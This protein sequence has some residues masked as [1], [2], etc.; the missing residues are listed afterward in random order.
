MSNV[1]GVLQ[2]YTTATQF[3]AAMQ[4]KLEQQEA[5]YGLMLGIALRLQAHPERIEQPPYLATVT[6]DQGTTAALMT[7]PHGLLLYSEQAEHTTALQLIADD[8]HANAWPLPT[9]NG[10]TPLSTTFAQIWSQLCKGGYE[11]A[12]RTRIFELR[13]VQSPPACPGTMRLATGA[14]LELVTSWVIAFE[15][16]ALSEEEADIA[17]PSTAS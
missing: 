7:P 3:L 2:T 16:E 13:Q 12:V 1:N 10:L 8:L 14:D 5:L 4:G 11:V 6:D 9:V 17:M 15:Q